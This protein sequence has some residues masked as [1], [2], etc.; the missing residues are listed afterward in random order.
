[1]DAARSAIREVRRRRTLAKEANNV[2]FVSGKL[3]KDTY[4]VT[5]A[6]DLVGITGIR[7]EALTDKRL[8]R[9]D[10]AG[11]PTATRCSASYASPPLRKR[12]PQRPSR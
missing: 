12:E 6:T 11:R 9:A 7:L 5:L 2:V 8:P 4:T 3:A 1:M 10:R